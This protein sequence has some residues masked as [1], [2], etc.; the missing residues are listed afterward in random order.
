MTSHELGI[1]KDVFGFISFFSLLLFVYKYH[2]RRSGWKKFSFSK[3]FCVC[4]VLSF[5]FSSLYIFNFRETFQRSFVAFDD[6]DPNAS[7][8]GVKS[9]VWGRF[10]MRR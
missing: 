3:H 1:R 7:G 6:G 4:R 9:K 10:L 8:V 5:N 2:H